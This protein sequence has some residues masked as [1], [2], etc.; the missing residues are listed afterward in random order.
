MAGM[1]ASPSISAAILGASGYTGMELIRL[2]AGHPDVRIAALCVR[3]PSA[4]QQTAPH[5]ASRADLPRPTVTGKTDLADCSIVFSCLPH[6]EAAAQIAQLDRKTRVIDLS[7]DLRLKDVATYRQW[8]G[9][10][11]PAPELL[12]EAVY[13]LCEWNRDAISKAR[14]IANPGCYPSCTI[15]PL[16]PLI[17][18]GKIDPENIIVDAISGI[19]GAGRSPQRGSLL[20]EVSIQPYA[21]ARHRHLPEIEDFLGT[22]TKATPLIEFVPHVTAISRGMCATIHVRMPSSVRVA[23]V[24]ESLRE[25]YAQSPFVLTLPLGPL[26]LG[27][28]PP[29]TS[30]VL[31]TN[32]CR[33]GVWPGRQADRAIIVSVI[34]NLGKGAAGQAVQNMNI[35]FSLDEDR[36]LKGAAIH[37]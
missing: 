6:G 8:Y 2:L 29:A 31:G 36:G 27:N 16:A 11:H 15:L 30:H 19:S 26:P 12:E 20:C 3:D 18:H 33:I 37:P 28:D 14:I 4:W 32:Q 1:T 25:C 21:V 23:D 9:R 22:L 34:D 13:G 35:L 7:A 24:A 17:K 5:L 10:E